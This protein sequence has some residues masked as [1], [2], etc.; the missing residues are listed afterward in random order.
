MAMPRQRRI[1]VA[2]LLTGCPKSA[3][4]TEQEPAT[5]DDGV[6][7]APEVAGESAAKRTRSRRALD[8]FPEE[9]LVW[10]IFVRLPAMVPWIS[11]AA[12][13]S[14]TP[15]AASSLPLISSSPTTGASRRSPSPCSTAARPVQVE[16]LATEFW[17]EAEAGL[18]SGSTTTLAS[19]CTP[20]AT[21]FLCS[22]DLTA[23]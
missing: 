23:A 9:I 5:D 6:A 11:S 21:A 14:A 16:R 20:P 2:S 17:G 3:A 12:A 13:R 4:G 10:E 8:G 19:S 22:A 1:L 18:S 7:I 15:A